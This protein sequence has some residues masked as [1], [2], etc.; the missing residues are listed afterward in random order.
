[1]AATMAAGSSKGCWNWSHDPRRHAPDG[2]WRRFDCPAGSV[3]AAAPVRVGIILYVNR[4]GSTLLSRLLAE[5]LEDTFVFPELRFTLDVLVALRRGRTIPPPELLRLMREDV[6]LAS[7]GLADEQLAAAARDHGARDLRGLLTA[8]ATAASGRRPR[9][10]ILKLEPYIGFIPELDTALTKPLLIH[11]LRDPRAVARSMLA[12]PVPEKPGFDMA[13]GS[14][15]YAARHWRDYM[16]RIDRLA[17]TRDVVTIRYERL[18]DPNALPLTAIADRLGTKIAQNAPSAFQIAPL[19]TAIHPHVHAPFDGARADQ[20]QHDLPTS[21]VALIE[22]ICATEMDR[23][24]YKRTTPS[25]GPAAL[26]IAHLRH[27]RAMTRHLLR[28]GRIYAERPDSLRR[29]AARLQL[30]RSAGEL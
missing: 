12:T 14:I 16:R 8:L 24:G 7:L 27:C 4:S 25:L 13:R 29:L 26:T 1:M 19:D 21:D 17:V 6:R 18:T 28:T 30:A 22:T 2:V 15:L 23:T 11:A 9:A 10:M 3:S 20:W 5:S